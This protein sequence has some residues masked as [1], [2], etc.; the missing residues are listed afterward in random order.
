MAVL[1]PAP[2]RTVALTTGSEAQRR[3]YR[4]SGSWG[5]YEADRARIAF[6]AFAGRSANQTGAAGREPIRGP[7]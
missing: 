1:P 4:V 5:H 7:S 6:E 2:Q 3:F